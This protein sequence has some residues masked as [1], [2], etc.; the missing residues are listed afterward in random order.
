MDIKSKANQRLYANALINNISPPVLRAFLMRLNRAHSEATYHLRD[1]PKGKA[2]W[3]A[4]DELRYLEESIARIAPYCTPEHTA[5]GL[6]FLRNIVYT[7]KG[8]RRD[9]EKSRFFTGRDIRVLDTACSIQLWDFTY[10]STTWVRKHWPVYRVNSGEH[11][12]SFCYV[13]TP[14]QAGGYFDITEH[15]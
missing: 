10:L 1:S 8:K 11:D 15:A 4:Y 9:T 2:R 6:A 3:E 7:P 13:M 5:S 14:W 12:S